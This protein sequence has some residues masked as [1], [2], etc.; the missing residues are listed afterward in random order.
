MRLSLVYKKLSSSTICK[1][2]EVVFH[3]Q[4]NWGCLPITLNWG[5]LLFPA[6]LPLYKVVLILSLGSWVGGSRVIIKLNSAQLELELG[7]SLAIRLIP[8]TPIGVL[9]LHFTAHWYVQKFSPPIALN[10]YSKFRK[11]KGHHGISIIREVLAR[12]NISH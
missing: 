9:A 6:Y 12:T 3:L 2:N 1:K 10:S 7:L 4:L 5:R 8:H 11:P